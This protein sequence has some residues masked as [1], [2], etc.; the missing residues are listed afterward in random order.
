MSA[1]PATYYHLHM[2]TYATA[3]EYRAYVPGL[4][5]DVTD[6]DIDDALEKAEEYI[7]SA[8]GRGNVL[9]ELRKFDPIYL[10]T[11]QQHFLS[12]ATCAQAEYMMH[13]G[14]TFFI[15]ARTGVQGRDASIQ[16]KLPALGPKA[17]QELTRGK[18]FRLTG[19]STGTPLPNQNFDDI[20]P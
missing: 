10:D 4:D 6:D 2:P 3:T 15:Q 14:E 11:Y 5:P 16:G 12:R 1:R 8:V 9:Y 7:D 20:I 17:R 13:M 19:R 18:L